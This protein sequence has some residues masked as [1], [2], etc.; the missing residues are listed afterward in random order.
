MLFKWTDEFFDLREIMVAI[1][2]D[3]DPKDSTKV[4]FEANV[5]V[6]SKRVK[7]W[8]YSLPKSSQTV[9]N[10]VHASWVV[11]LGNMSESVRESLVEVK[12]V[13]EE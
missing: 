9:I 7:R 10:S 4:E 3:E 12:D 2:K 8:K 13:R 6:N 11:T 1:R 5:L